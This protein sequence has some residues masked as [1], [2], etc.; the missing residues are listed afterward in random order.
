MYGAQRKENEHGHVS[1]SNEHQQPHQ[2]SGDLS[3]VSQQLQHTSQPQQQQGGFANFIQQ[4]QQQNRGD[5]H[6]GL[7]NLSPGLVLQSQQQQG[8]G[9][10]RSGAAPQQT[11]LPQ[12]QKQEVFLNQQ[13][14]QPPFQQ[15]V[16][17]SPPLAHEP[18]QYNAI[19]NL[20][21]IALSQPARAPNQGW[22]QQ[23]ELQENNRTLTE[24]SSVSKQPYMQADDKHSF[25]IPS[26]TQDLTGVET[27]S[28][29]VSS[30]PDPA[31]A[32]APSVSS[33]KD[34]SKYMKGQVSHGSLIPFD[35]F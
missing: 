2:T 25:N 8:F 11:Q 9:N 13:Q 23:N 35:N 1:S 16:Q 19:S 10:F 28:P 18:M 32:G 27:P 20:Q 4:P 31:F 15:S 30:T 12:Q 3:V 29:A 21:N 34:G 22:I 17:Q 14:E 7:A 24:G 33:S 26:P 5:Q 6:H